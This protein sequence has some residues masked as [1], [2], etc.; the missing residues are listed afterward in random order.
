MKRP[1]D[2]ALAAALLLCLAMA[3][4]AAAQPSPAED[5]PT[6]NMAYV[7]EAP[8]AG[9]GSEDTV[10][11]DGSEDAM[12]GDEPQADETE[13]DAEAW[14]DDGSSAAAG[15]GDTAASESEE[16]TSEQVKGG[17]KRM[18][19]G[20]LLPAVEREVRKAVGSDDDA[21]A[22]AGAEPEPGADP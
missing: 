12:A 10:A 19:I 9:D 21:Q 3:G 7:D 13:A 16:S 22:N 11:E 17:L 15:E 8:M 18:L 4:Q 1:L 2:T 5:E 6:E 20:L 14:S